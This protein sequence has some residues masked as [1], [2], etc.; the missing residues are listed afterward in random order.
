MFALVRSVE[1]RRMTAALIALAALAAACAPAQTPTPHPTYPA[2]STAYETRGARVEYGDL[3]TVVEVPPF[4]FS[5]ALAP[6]SASPLDGL[7]YKVI[8]LTATPTPCKRCAGYRLEGGAWTLY[9]DKGVYK[10]FL[11]ETGFES[12]G[13]FAVSGQHLALTNDPY[14]EE[15][16]AMTGNYTWELD[17]QGLRLTT[18]EDACSYKLRGQNLTSAAWT[19]VPA[20]ASERADLCQAIN[21]GAAPGEEWKKPPFCR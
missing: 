21:R 7:Y 8:P 18:V 1:V 9:L 15:D 6:A 12:I 14:C 13:S 20:A 10:V 5:G 19:R 11:Q 16:L 17:G 3:S 2:P 4:P